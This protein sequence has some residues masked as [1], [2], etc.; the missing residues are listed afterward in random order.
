MAVRLS[1]MSDQRYGQF[2]VQQGAEL[3]LV[4]TMRPAPRTSSSGRHCKAGRI[5]FGA[6]ARCTL[7]GIIEGDFAVRIYAVRS[8]HL[9]NSLSQDGGAWKYT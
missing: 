5:A 4:S 1:M 7:G 2:S 6:F 8:I 9:A 3:L